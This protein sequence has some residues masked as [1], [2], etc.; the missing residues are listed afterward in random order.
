METNLSSISSEQD[1]IHRH[2]LLTLHI[3]YPPFNT[4]PFPEAM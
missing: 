3:S 4:D 1:W 2:G